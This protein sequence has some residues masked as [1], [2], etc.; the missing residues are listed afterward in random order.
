[1]LKFSM[2][3]YKITNKTLWLHQGKRWLRNICPGRFFSTER[4]SHVLSNSLQKTQLAHK[5]SFLFHSKDTSKRSRLILK[6]QA[7][8]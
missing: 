6:P 7:S 1:M 8:K 2:V 5:P 4:G 3:T